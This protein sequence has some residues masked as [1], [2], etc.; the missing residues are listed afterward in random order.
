MFYVS[1]EVIIDQYTIN[2][3][4]RKI[5]YKLINLEIKNYLIKQI[6]DISFILNTIYFFFNCLHLL[7][8]VLIINSCITIKNKKFIH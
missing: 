3:F 8:Q 5:I 4:H 7:L 6:S 1:V 2:I